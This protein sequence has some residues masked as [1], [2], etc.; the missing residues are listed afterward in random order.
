MVFYN[1]DKTIF[2]ILTLLYLYS[3][4]LESILLMYYNKIYNALPILF[5]LLFLSSC[6]SE[7]ENDLSENDSKKVEEQPVRDSAKKY[8]YLTFDDGP[9]NGSWQIDSVI[10]N[11]KI[12]VSAFLVGKNANMSKKYGIPSGNYLSNPLIDTYNH[13]FSHAYD[14]YISFYNKPDSVLKDIQ[15]NDAYFN[16]KYKHLRLAGRNIWNTGK[17]KKT[18]GNSGS[19]ASDVLVQNGYKVYGWDIEWHHKKNGKPLQTVDKMIH[20]V[21]WIFEQQKEFT[22][23]NLVVLMHDEMFQKPEEINKLTEFI[24]KLKQHPDYVFEHIRFYPD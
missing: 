1:K 19:A 10:T 4:F 6:F 17:R 15:K 24:Q 18:D 11:E 16:F 9:I 8:I 13:T 21:E 2:Y 20:G 23:N 7:K 5:S 12:K 3:C 14:N 22:K